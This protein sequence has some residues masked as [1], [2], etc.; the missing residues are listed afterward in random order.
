MNFIKEYWASMLLYLALLLLFVISIEVKTC[1]T[2]I[3][4]VSLQLQAPI[5][6]FKD[7][8]GAQHSIVNLQ[9]TT[10]M[11]NIIDSLKL[12]L[13]AKKVQTVIRTVVQIDTV[14]QNLPV[15]ID[16]T[17]GEIST[18]K[19]DDYIDITVAINLKNK[20]SS[21]GLV[22]IDTL[23]Q[24]IEKKKH[25]FKANELFIENINK[26]PYNHIVAGNAITLKEPKVLFTV[27][28]ALIYNPFTSRVD[29]GIGITYNLFSIKA[30]K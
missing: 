4:P 29:L 7:P 28:P 13:K 24:V 30:K 25:W 1:K 12:A 23:T 8:S 11:Q 20:M 22:S 9:E 17:T 21:I 6:Q 3:K 19:H 14:F 15:Y 5:K 16:T 27:G 2:Y 26:N 18:D 10:S